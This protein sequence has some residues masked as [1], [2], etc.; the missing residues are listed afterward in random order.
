MLDEIPTLTLL[1]KIDKKFP[2][3]I[4]R[5]R[6]IMAT[7]DTTMRYGAVPKEQIQIFDAALERVQ[8]EPPEEACRSFV[9]MIDLVKSLLATEQTI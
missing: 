4:H 6:L 9:R 8:L 7:E 5:R 1:D 2:E 3:N